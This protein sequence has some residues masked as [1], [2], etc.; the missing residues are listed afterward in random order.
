MVEFGLRVCVGF[1]VQETG[2][3]T[4]LGGAQPFPLMSR[5]ASGGVFY[6]GISELSM[7]LGNLSAD[8]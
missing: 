8:G 2:A 4:L 7:T 5:V 6:G 1:L 3:C